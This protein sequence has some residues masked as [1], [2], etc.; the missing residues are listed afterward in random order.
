M[1]FVDVDTSKEMLLHCTSGGIGVFTVHQ[2]REIVAFAEQRWLPAIFLYTFPDFNKISTL[3]GGAKLDYSL[4]CFSYSGPYFASYSSTPDFV[5]IIW[6]WRNGTQLCSQSTQRMEATTL[7]FNPMNQFQL[8]MSSEDALILWTIERCSELH[9]LRE[10]HIKLLVEDGSLPT[11][12]ETELSESSTPLAY[13]GP[14]M[15]ISA[16]GGLVGDEAI[17][18]VVSTLPTYYYCFS[19]WPWGGVGIGK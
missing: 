10:Q 4:L 12:E 14:E 5:L 2:T 15:P 16:I 6:N 1:I 18:F 11:P 3:K 13:L 17:E 7:T 19:V 8:C 9:I